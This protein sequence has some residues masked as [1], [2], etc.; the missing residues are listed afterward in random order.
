MM[1][2]ND[3]LNR[4]FFL[5]DMGFVGSHACGTRNYQMGTTF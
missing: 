4:C 5:R 3:V 1:T 2:F